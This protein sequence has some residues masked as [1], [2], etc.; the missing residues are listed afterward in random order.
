MNPQSTLDTG[1]PRYRASV[2]RE[3][4]RA[5][6]VPVN[7]VFA[8]MQSTFGSCYVNDFNYL[9]RLW[10]VNLQS[11]ADFRSQ[12]EDIQNV[13]VRS[14]TGTMIPLSE[15]VHLERESG[16][17][18][19]NRFIVYP[20]ARLLADPAPGYTTGQAK[21]A[22]ESVVDSLE[23][24]HGLMLGWT[25]EA[26]QLDAASGAGG[27][28]FGLGL[29]MV[30]LILA[31]Q[32]ERWTL[33]LA[34]ATAVPFGVLG[35]TVASHFR[36]YPNDVYFQVG[37]L[38]LIGLASKNAILIVEFAAQNRKQG[39]ST[40]DSARQAARQ[41]FRPIVM[42]AATFIMGS[43][44]LV[45]ASGAGAAS[46]R[47]IGTVVVGGMILASTFALPFVALMY[48]S[49][50]NLSDRVYRKRDSSTSETTHA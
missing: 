18:I 11:E 13:F 43:L 41:R 22:M 29:L 32:Y 25:G 4:A 17:D 36:G 9:G 44:P 12:P 46:R 34:V 6:G 40:G 33:P 7:Q 49:L 45:F 2:D 28:A 10:Q 39:M 5:M 50:E 3:K 30:F 47:E 19:L 42:T 23:S 35:A 16:A 1:I 27:A 31:A 26:Y 15:L 8:V 14:D 24:E 20:A 21:K 38:V 48:Q 37:L